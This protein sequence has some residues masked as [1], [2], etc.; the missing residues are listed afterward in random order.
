MP[1]YVPT[2]NEKIELLKQH[3]YYEV[4]LIGEGAALWY[5]LNYPHN[6]SL[7]YTLPTF[8][9]SLRRLINNMC[10]EAVP[11]HARGLIPFFTSELRGRGGR[12][13]DALARDFMKDGETWTRPIIDQTNYP[14][15]TKVQDRVDKELAHLSYERIPVARLQTHW[16]L[17]GITMEISSMITEFIPKCKDD[18]VSPEIRTCLLT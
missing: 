16:D 7:G 6:Y 4:Q 11:L 14:N 5:A 13:K 17:A 10:L 9:P 12:D 15:L 18:Y 2:E 3:F 1:E 8:T